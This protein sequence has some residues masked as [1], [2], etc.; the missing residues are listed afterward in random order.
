[1][2]CFSHDSTTLASLH[3]AHSNKHVA[4]RLWNVRTGEERLS[5]SPGK[6]GRGWPDLRRTKFRFS[7]DDRV[8]IT[9]WNSGVH[10]LVEYWN[11]LT[12]DLE[13]TFGSAPEQATPRAKLIDTAPD[14]CLVAMTWFSRTVDVLDLRT[15]SQ[16]RL[17]DEHFHIVT[18]IAF[19][20]D[21]QHIATGTADGTVCSWNIKTGHRTCMPSECRSQIHK[22][23]YLPSNPLILA[24]ASDDC[25]IRVWNL[26]TGEPIRTLD[27]HKSPVDSLFFISGG[28]F[29]VSGSIDQEIKVWEVST[30]KQI[31]EFRGHS[32][33]PR[34]QIAFS[35]DRSLL[36]LTDA[37]GCIHLIDL[38]TMERV[39]TLGWESVSLQ[40]PS[41]MRCMTFSYTGL[42]IAASQYKHTRVWDL[43]TAN[44]GTS[45]QIDCAAEELMFSADDTTLVGLA[46]DDHPRKFV[47]IWQAR[48]GKLIRTI[49][50]RP[51]EEICAA[52][53][54]SDHQVMTLALSKEQVKLFEHPPGQDPEPKYSLLDDRTESTDLSADGELTLTGSSHGAV[55]LWRTLTGER[56]RKF[57]RYGSCVEAAALSQV[58]DSVI[59]VFS[60]CT[61]QSWNL[62]D[63]EHLWTVDVSHWP[64]QD[65]HGLNSPQTPIIFSTDGRMLALWNGRTFELRCTRTGRLLDEVQ[66]ADV[67]IGDHYFRAHFPNLSSPA[68]IIVES[69]AGSPEHMSFREMIE[70]VGWIGHSYAFPALSSNGKLVA[71][72]TIPPCGAVQLW[73][74]ARLY[75]YTGDK[76]SL[77]P[78]IAK[79]QVRQVSFSPDNRTVVATADHSTKLW[80]AAESIEDFEFDISPL[81]PLRATTSLDGSLI[82]VWDSS[83]FTQVLNVSTSKLVG[84]LRIKDTIIAQMLPGSAQDLAVSELVFLPT[85]QVLACA[86]TTSE[87]FVLIWDSHIRRTLMLESTGKHHGV[88]H[89]ALAFTPD[90]N[91]LVLVAIEGTQGIKQPA[92]HCMLIW[93]LK[94]AKL[95]GRHTII[96]DNVK[97]VT[98][99][100]DA[101][102]VVTAS[103]SGVIVWE[104]S[105]ATQVQV[106]EWP[107]NCIPSDGSDWSC[108]V[109]DQTQVR[110]STD[111][112]TVYTSSF[113]TYTLEWS[114]SF[115]QLEA[116]KRIASMEY[117]SPWI[118]HRDDDLVCVPHGYGTHFDLALNTLVI[119]QST[120]D[121][122][123]FFQ[124]VNGH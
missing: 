122:L 71:T 86:Y 109:L 11:T 72:L 18:A 114:S 82:A 68:N 43:S 29:M 49:S 22:L 87:I 1:M 52:L 19:S 67:G 41:K 2:L 27:G 55:E 116:L 8:L 30:R 6:I 115:R 117:I 77:S 12:G 63:G 13:H 58:A 59:S 62:H 104:R 10:S 88:A 28:E 78:K 38:L 95:S 3:Q 53:V 31:Y 69:R 119:D 60:N 99:T 121:T 110:F 123:A 76:S 105:N 89:S 94:S 26:C 113:G 96:Q 57:C 80:D 35:S 54:I 74:P 85:Q 102:L 14:G 75:S 64:I 50:S 84:T 118:R 25:T 91:T 9:A 83:A 46:Y 23:T 44:K 101:Q 51:N 97:A 56:V 4:I 65:N 100:P 33:F 79:S 7:N 90:G 81:K 36:A 37:G 120:L 32:C 34:A 111:G 124:L 40:E 47:Q 48:T 112:L 16:V 108:A 106:L 73:D 103:A 70:F 107:V 66:Q 61:V 45:Y 42:Q 15:M 39:E 20:H 98:L 21:S 92:K 17:L 5:I 24:S 93:D